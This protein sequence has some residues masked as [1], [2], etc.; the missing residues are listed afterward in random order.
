MRQQRVATRRPRPR[1]FTGAFTAAAIATAAATG[2]GYLLAF[3]SLVGWVVLGLGAA[4]ALSLW[5]EARPARHATPP[6]AT[7][8]TLPAQRGPGDS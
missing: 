1:T 6:P 7:G 5:L 3:S 8:V 2:L 4:I